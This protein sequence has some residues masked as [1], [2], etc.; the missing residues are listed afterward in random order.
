[1]ERPDGL[2]GAIIVHKRVDTRR[3]ELCTG[4]ENVLVMSEW[5]HESSQQLYTQ[6]IGPGYYPNGAAYPFA[7]YNWTRAVD[8]RMV[9]PR[10]CALVNR[11]VVSRCDGQCW[12]R[13]G[14]SQTP[15]TIPS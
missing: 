15:A 14:I 2:F 11:R 13:T 3:D 6:R 8:S 9:W 5:Y 1:M 10:V 12:L 7:P 4:G